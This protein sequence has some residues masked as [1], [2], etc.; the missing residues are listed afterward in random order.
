VFERVDVGDPEDVANDRSRRRTPP[1]THR[2]VFISSRLD[3]IGNDEEVRGEAHL[4]DEV[5]LIADA[6]F[7]LLGGVGIAA[8]KALAAFAGQLLVGR[9]VAIEKRV[10]RKMVLARLER[11]SGKATWS[12][13]GVTR[14][15]PR[16]CVKCALF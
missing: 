4:V 12:A 7:V 10:V 3:Q 13:D 5:E 6:V 9:Q 11:E 2:N 16:L 15:R 8:E 14:N 1:R